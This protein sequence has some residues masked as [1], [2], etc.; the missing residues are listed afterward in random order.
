MVRGEMVA[1]RL[2]GGAQKQGLNPW[3]RVNFG[4]L[5]VSAILYS[6]TSTCSRRIVSPPGT[7]VKV[8][9]LPLRSI[10]QVTMAAPIPPGHMP[11]YIKN[12]TADMLVSPFYILCTRQLWRRL[13]LFVYLIGGQIQEMEDKLGS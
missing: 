12:S 1:P 13:G 5:F 7:L 4:F 6:T 11:H 10:Y 8:Q 3:A 2:L 9:N